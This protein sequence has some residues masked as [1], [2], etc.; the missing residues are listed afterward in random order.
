MIN[1]REITG[2]LQITRPLNLLIA[3]LAMVSMRYGLNHRLLGGELSASGWVFAESVGVM[4]LLMA[5]G[6]LINDYFDIKEDRI[7]HPERGAIGRSVPRRDLIK[8]H[9]TLSLAAM[10]LACDLSMR[11]GDWTVAL[12][13][14]V[15]GALLWWYSS[16]L[17]GK[18]VWGNV[19]VALLTGLVPLW[20][21]LPELGDSESLTALARTERLE[22]LQWAAAFGFMAFAVSWV[23]EII[24][25]IIDIPGDQAAGHRTMAVKWGAERSKKVARFVQLIVT[26]LYAAAAGYWLSSI[27]DPVSLAASIALV[28]PGLAMATTAFLLR[29]STKI[30]WADYAAKITLV[31]GFA[32]AFWLPLH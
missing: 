27:G 5:A 11:I 15:I 18:F 30:K 28:L 24:K 14:T 23:R 29:S 17:K 10:A 21:V 16:A 7:N 4:L 2:L 8:A 31:I 32:V 9:A 13:A 6:N 12:L 26:V 19:L 3:A 20:A 25:D 1:H 22:L